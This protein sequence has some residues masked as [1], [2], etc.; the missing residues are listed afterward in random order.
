MTYTHD[1]VWPCFEII[2]NSSNLSYVIALIFVTMY[3][4][5]LWNN[6]KKIDQY[7]TTTKQSNYCVIMPMSLQY[8]LWAVHF[9]SPKY[10]FYTYN[11]VQFHAT[12]H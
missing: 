3:T 6:P 1:F 10:N 11:L 5:S 4:Q 12:L 8:R 9:I 2:I 7:L